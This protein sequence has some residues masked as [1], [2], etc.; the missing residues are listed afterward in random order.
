MRTKSVSQVRAHP[1]TPCDCFFHCVAGRRTFR[2]WQRW[3][4]RRTGRWRCSRACWWVCRTRR[5]GRA[6]PSP[7]TLRPRAGTDLQKRSD[8]LSLNPPKNSW[9]PSWHAT[10]NREQN[11]S[12]W[13]LQDSALETQITM[14][15]RWCENASRSSEFHSLCHSEPD[16]GSA[17][18]FPQII[19]RNWQTCIRTDTTLSV[20]SGRCTKGNPMTHSRVISWWGSSFHRL[21]LDKCHLITRRSQTRTR[22]WTSTKDKMW[23]TTDLSSC[24]VH[25]K[26]EGTNF[27]QSKKMAFI[28]VPFNTTEKLAVRIVAIFIVDCSFQN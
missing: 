21:M 9:R 14:W 26:L 23:C 5:S 6:R 15:N 11:D 3:W 25:R 24:R 2:T 18:G 20:S 28:P 7:S 19:M 16:S 27:A 12:L 1:I 22:A 13:C 8:T 4:A 17:L 10:N